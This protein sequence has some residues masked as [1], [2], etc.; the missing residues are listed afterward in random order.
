[1]RPAA[2]AIPVDVGGENP[3]MTT[4]KNGHVKTQFSA[5]PR[6]GDIRR[7]AQSGYASVDSDYL[8]VFPADI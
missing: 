4:L 3:I 2:H 6:P 5:I 1:M 8:P 7:R